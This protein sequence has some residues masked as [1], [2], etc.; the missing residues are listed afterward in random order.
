MDQ[1]QRVVIVVVDGILNGASADRWLATEVF[2]ELA[3][4][5]GEGNIRIFEET[6]LKPLQ[7]P[8]LEM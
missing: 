3:A 4:K 8:P 2:V 5:V 6:C 7:M 1:L